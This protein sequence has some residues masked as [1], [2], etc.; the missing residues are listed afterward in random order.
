MTDKKLTK[1]WIVNGFLGHKRELFKFLLNIEKQLK[2]KKFGNRKV[3]QM[4]TYLYGIDSGIPF[5]FK[6]QKFQ[7]FLSAV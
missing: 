7:F 6:L 5:S 1:G 3:G 4:D 2:E